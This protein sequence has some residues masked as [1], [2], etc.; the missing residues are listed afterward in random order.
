MSATKPLPK[1]ILNFCW[2]IQLDTYVLYGLLGYILIILIL[3]I[4]MRKWWNRKEQQ[5]ENKFIS[6]LLFLDL[7]VWYILQNDAYN[8]LNSMVSGVRMSHDLS[9]T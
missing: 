9:W 7:I 8:S 2:Y 6:V 3:E 4:H 1:P 5:A